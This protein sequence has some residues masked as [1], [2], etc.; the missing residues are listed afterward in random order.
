MDRQ[1][2]KK[3]RTT[4]AGG[5]TSRINAKEAKGIGCLPDQQAA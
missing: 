2:T 3:S 5:A 4:L 1:Q